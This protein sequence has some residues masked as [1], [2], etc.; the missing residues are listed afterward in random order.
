M[1][2]YYATSSLNF[3]DIFA[4]ESISPTSFYSKRSFG[5]SKHM[6]TELDFNDCLLILFTQP[7]YFSLV[8]K[9]DSDYEQY[10]ILLKFDISN[11]DTSFIKISDDIYITYSTIYFSNNRPKVYFFNNDH[12][13][14]TLAK[15]KL[16]SETKTVSKY[17]D[18]FEL[19]NQNIL[20]QF[21][22]PPQLY[23]YNNSNIAYHMKYDEIYNSI[24][25][26]YYCYLSSKYVSKYLQLAEEHQNRLLQLDYINNA[27]K[28][29]STL[30]NISIKY[31]NNNLTISKVTLEEYID[32]LTLQLE[33]MM[34]SMNCFSF[35]NNF[36]RINSTNPLNYDLKAFEAILNTIIQNPKSTPGIIGPDEIPR[37]ISKINL[38]LTNQKLPSN[39][40]SDVNL[41]YKR[42]VKRDLDITL[43]NITTTVMQNLY[44]FLLKYDNLDELTK[45]I[46]TKGLKNNYICY[47]LYGAFYGFSG[48]SKV[49]LNN[50]FSSN[51]TDLFDIL[52]YNLKPCINQ[53][54]SQ[55]KTTAH[56][57][58]NNKPI[59]SNNVLPYSSKTLNSVDSKVLEQKI[60]TEIGLLK[61]SAS[62]KKLLIS[63][64]Y[65]FKLSDFIWI[66]C[67]SE[68]N[69]SNINICLGCN[70]MNLQFSI[71]LIHKSVSSIPEKKEFKQ[72]LS[73]I[74]MDKK[75][76]SSITSG[77]YDTV[78]VVQVIE[79]KKL[80]LTTLPP[81]YQSLLLDCLN[82]LNN[83]K[84]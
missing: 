49:L 43:D 34:S 84:L 52:D 53:L 77:N 6:V 27:I 78:N 7:P 5:T 71:L 56:S 18:D 45:F 63:K 2:L 46:T 38:S 75:I 57:S 62:I 40:I 4:T 32:D 9:N 60:F 24:K 79:D 20:N 29:N 33:A 61:K 15:S 3:N 41:I 23:S 17:H 55:L 16:V 37:L 74:K 13:N 65:K 51:F 11:T 76:S 22:I 25:G 69:N 58:T 64:Q 70:S 42:I 67:I 14:I 47:S 31:I 82:Y 26:A 39:Y 10:P 8:D 28:L 68:D 21:Q 19:I 12:L 44:T 83:S 36:L 66:A 73:S 30:N 59:T 48:I 80:P 54:K 35:I 72:Y 81:K 50:I 1:Y